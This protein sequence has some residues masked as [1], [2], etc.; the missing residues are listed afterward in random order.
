[1]FEN[2]LTP[3]GSAV[4]RLRKGATLALSLAA[5]SLAVAAVIVVPLLRA[6]G[7]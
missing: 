1:M 6:A 2:L 3:G 5:H 7:P 4:K